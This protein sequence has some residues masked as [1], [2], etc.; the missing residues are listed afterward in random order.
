MEGA[1]I[2]RIARYHKPPGIPCEFQYSKHCRAGRGVFGGVGG[3]L[4]IGAREFF[5]VLGDAS[6]RVLGDGAVRTREDLP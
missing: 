2:T 4:C 6:V 3:S 1:A 5:E